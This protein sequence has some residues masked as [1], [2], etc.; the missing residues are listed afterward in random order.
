[1]TISIPKKSFPDLI[2]AALGKKRAIKVPEGIYEKFG[3][4]VYASAQKESFWKALLRPRDENPPEGF[5]YV[6]G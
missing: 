6:D 5:I 2:L 4:Y 1:M 3:P